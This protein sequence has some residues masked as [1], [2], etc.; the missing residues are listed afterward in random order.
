MLLYGESLSSFDVVVEGVAGARLAGAG[1]TV[2]HVADNFVPTDLMIE[3]TQN[4]RP[5]SEF[6][7]GHGTARVELSG[8]AG[9]GA[10]LDWSA[11]DSALLEAAV[12][13]HDSLSVDLEG[14]SEGLYRVGVR[15]SQDDG[16][17][18]VTD[19]LRIA[20]SV[21]SGEDCDGPG[22][23][24][25]GQ[26]RVPDCVLDDDRRFVL[27][28]GGEWYDVI[29][30]DSGLNLRLGV[31]AYAKGDHSPLLNREDVTIYGGDDG[32][33]VSTADQ[34]TGRFQIP[35]RLFDVQV[36]GLS[37]PG[38][39]ASVVFPLS[40]AIEENSILTVFEAEAGWREFAVSDQDIVRATQRID[41]VCPAPGQPAYRAPWESGDNCIEVN[42]TD[43]GRNDVSA[44]AN[45][46]V[47]L[48][49]G[50]GRLETET[51]DQNETEG[52]SSSSPSVGQSGDGSQS[53]GGGLMV[54]LPL[55]LFL[56]LC[57]AALAGLR[58]KPGKQ[59]R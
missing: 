6:Q 13:D 5:V 38:G 22:A 8:H 37:V 27:P 21:G 42:V 24:D 43:G 17:R 29:Q 25:Q 7:P 11:S 3:L 46:V 58:S 34:A 44:E 19:H 9:P 57:S 35:G 16:E 51:D 32:S 1:R 12:V 59:Y 47:A 2:V 36:R 15:V 23:R 45:G 49:V 54:V 30:A 48:R 41:G 50:V 4:E 40:D 26:T 53:R 28:S 39:T 56:Y 18:L 31:A 52:G 14:L 55:I 10:Q 33:M 20:S